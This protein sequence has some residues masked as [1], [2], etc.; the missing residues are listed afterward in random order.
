V[1]SV[2][3]LVGGL[4]FLWNL[5]DGDW[6]QKRKGVDLVWLN[7]PLPRCVLPDAD[8]AKYDARQDRPW[9]PTEV[10]GALELAKSILPPAGVLV[11]VAPVGF[12]ESALEGTSYSGVVTAVRSTVTLVMDF[13]KSKVRLS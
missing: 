12:P 5:D 9:E 1:P 2:E 11:V 4:E 13:K 6:E 8:A 10:A 3:K 7:V